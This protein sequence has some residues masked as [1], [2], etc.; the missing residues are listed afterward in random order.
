MKRKGV[1]GWA[2]RQIDP[3]DESQPWPLWLRL[4]VLAGLVFVVLRLFGLV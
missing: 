4:L 1:Y 2:R 3:T